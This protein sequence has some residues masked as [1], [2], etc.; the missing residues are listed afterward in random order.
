MAQFPQQFRQPGLAVQI[1]TV[2]GG[3]LC[4][5][6]QFR[7]MVLCQPACLVQHVLHGYAAVRSANGR[8]GTIGTVVGTALGNFQVCK[9]GQ[10]GNDPVALHFSI[11]LFAELHDTFSSQHVVENVH[12]VPIVA[13]ANDGICL[14]EQFRRFFLIAFCQAAGQNDLFQGAVLFQGT[15]FQNGFDRFFFG[16]LDKSAG[17]YDCNVS[18]TGLCHKL[19]AVGTQLCQHTLRIDQILGTS[20]RNHAYTNWHIFSSI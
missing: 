4:N 19:I 3:V 20:Q 16:G 18:F 7:H 5:D 9:K 12:N 13:D 14:G 1:D 17:V 15:Q 6:D 11:A 8:N 10:G 2:S